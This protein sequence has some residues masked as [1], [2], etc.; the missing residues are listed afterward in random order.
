ML[1]PQVIKIECQSDDEP[2]EDNFT[3]QMFIDN[4]SGN[5]EALTIA[6]NPQPRWSR[7]S[8]QSSVA[9][10]AE[11][12]QCATP[13]ETCGTLRFGDL[14]VTTKEAAKVKEF[15]QQMRTQDTPER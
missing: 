10:S 6:H 13:M 12:Q 3:G 7:K 14:N 8:K 11:A 9:T 5:I 2:M 15:L 4:E 1:Q